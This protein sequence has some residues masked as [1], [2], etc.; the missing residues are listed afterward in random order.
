[1]L[2]SLEIKNFKG[3][4]SGTIS[5]LAQVNVL[6]GRNNSGKSTVLDAL[7]LMRCGFALMGH[8]GNNGLEQ[9]IKR[10]IN[11]GAVDLTELHYMRDTGQRV[12]ITAG[13]DDSTKVVEDWESPQQRFSFL[14]HAKGSSDGWANDIGVGLA[15][16]VFNALTS[17]HGQDLVNN[18]R[19]RMSLCSYYP[20]ACTTILS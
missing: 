16:S 15:S 8:T 14:I 17:K 6:V 10:K 20:W 12:S 1:M 19:Y 2:S 3:I 13:F 5:N 11:R 4:K 9:I 18:S 7:L